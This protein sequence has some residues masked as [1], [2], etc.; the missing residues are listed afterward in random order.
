M[1]KEQ[2]YRETVRIA[3]FQSLRN[4]LEL[5]VKLLEGIRQARETLAVEST[6]VE[7]AR[8]AFRHAVEALDRMPQLEPE[9]MKEVQ[10]LM[11][12]FRSALA[13]LQM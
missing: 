10:R 13:A 2:D 1:A 12:A 5:A 9:D 6:A 3:A 4:E 8:S 7:S 11:D